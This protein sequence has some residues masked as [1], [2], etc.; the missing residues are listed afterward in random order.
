MISKFIRRKEEGRGYKEEKGK[1]NF[2]PD[3]INYV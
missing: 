2:L 1:D 3:I